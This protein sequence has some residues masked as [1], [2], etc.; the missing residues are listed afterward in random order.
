MKNN[1]KFQKKFGSILKISGL[2]LWVII[3]VILNFLLTKRTILFV[4]DQKIR[5]INFSPLLQMSLLTLS[6]FIG[7]V[8]VQSLQSY[9]IIKE[10]SDEVEHLKSLNSYFEN[11]FESVNNKLKK[12]TEYMYQINNTNYK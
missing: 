2:Y 4:S 7:N 12:L 8:F 3:K 6:L 10:K 11:E 9:K 5:K 1:H